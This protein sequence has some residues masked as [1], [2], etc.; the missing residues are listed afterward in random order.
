MS[1]LPVKLVFPEDLVKKPMLGLLARDHG[2]LANI[3][4]ASVDENA[5]WIICELEGDP[6]KVERGLAWLREQGVEV[7]LLGDV[8]EG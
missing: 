3:R 6:H 4:R 1:G 7:E 2:V 8:V 5:G